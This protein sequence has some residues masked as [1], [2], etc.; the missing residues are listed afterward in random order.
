MYQKGIS[1]RKFLKGMAGGAAALAALSSGMPVWAQR[2]GLQ[3]VVWSYSIETIQDNIVR[4]QQRYPGL[5]VS[6]S[7]FGW[8]QYRP[9][10]VS[11]FMG[12]TATDVLYNGGDWL[13]EFALAGW[14]VPLERYFPQVL[15]YK[16]EIAGYALSEM[17]YNGELYGLPY[18]ADLHTF[19]Y[20]ER[21]LEEHGFTKPPETWEDVRDYSLKLKADGIKYP[22]M[23]EVAE[24]LP[25]FL[26]TFW[27][28]VYGRG[29]RPFDG[30]LN[31]VFN[32]RNH[33][34][35]KQ[36]QFYA[37]SINKWEI[38]TFLPHESKV[39][40]AMGTGQHA[41]TFMFNYMLA[42]LNNPGVNPL[43]GEFR[44]GL[45]PGKA[46]RCL[47]FAKF[48]CMTQMAAARGK[49]V[50]DAA[51]KFIEYF[52]GKTDGEYRVAKQW[53]LEKGLGFAQLPL[54]DDPDVRAAWKSWIDM[55]VYKQQAELAWAPVRTEWYG[56]WSPFM[57]AQMV[58]TLAGEISVGR[59]LNN[60]ARRW[61]ELKEEFS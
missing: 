48:Y 24:D 41:F 29:E 39:A 49:E 7:D 31:P 8:T 51:W 30:D 2:I 52:G 32:N 43:A 17:T 21:I 25:N 18:Y 19:M 15:D 44:L 6:L 59:A 58:Q 42:Q 40:P 13:P 53:A 26:D 1:R 57:R 16:D 61:D 33:A 37:D 10:M 27:S 28:M 9:T 60:A 36:L 55:S 22:I 54:Y 12:H 20:N 11:R 5:T 38:A 4:F 3:F 46:H 23:Y 56:V 35:Y 14:V 45:M 50:R 34:A 47:G